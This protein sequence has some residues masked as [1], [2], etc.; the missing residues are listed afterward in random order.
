MG[1]LFLNAWLK[2]MTRYVVS[3]NGLDRY[4]VSKVRLRGVEMYDDDGGWVAV[5]ITVLTR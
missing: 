1:N 2:F 4:I 5:P 3:K